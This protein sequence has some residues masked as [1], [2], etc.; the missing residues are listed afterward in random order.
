MSIQSPKAQFKI[1]RQ[2]RSQSQRARRSRSTFA[3]RS[4]GEGG[5][6]SQLPISACV[7]YTRDYPKKN[8]A[9]AAKRTAKKNASGAKAKVKRN[10][11]KSARRTARSKPKG[12]ACPIVGIGGSAGGFEAAMELLRHLPS[13]T[14][15]AFVI[16]QHLD[17]HH[18]SRFPSC[19]AK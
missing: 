4:L 15:M 16:V 14:G 19:S 5:V 17:P 2:S 13:K 9:M 10:G 11:A 8:A 7:I 1:W 3:R 12:L 18:A 6:A